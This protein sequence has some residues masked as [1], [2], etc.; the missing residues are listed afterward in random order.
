MNQFEYEKSNQPIRLLGGMVPLFIY[1]LV[2]STVV[3]VGVGILQSFLEKEMMSQRG[4]LYGQ[5]GIGMLG[6]LL[7]AVSVLHFYQRE[8]H[9]A[10]KNKEE[11]KKVSFLGRDVALI[12]A[13]GAGTSLFLNWIFTLIGFMQNSKAYQQ[14][15]EKQFSLPFWLA[16]LFYGMLSPWAEEVVFRGIFYRFL[17]RHT[18]AR[19]AIIGSAVMF[20]VFHGNVVQMVYGTMMGI[21][22]AGIYEKYKN[23]WAPVLFHGAANTAVYFVS[24]FF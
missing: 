16:F 10:K 9:Y 4:F 14:V 3:S 17:K 24:C 22:M 11:K 21:F 13:L 19:F 23:L 2:N 15:A 7:A 8:E 18:G 5:A 1:S 20:G 12:L 6:M